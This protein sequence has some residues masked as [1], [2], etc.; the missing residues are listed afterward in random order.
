MGS[1]KCGTGVGVRRLS[2]WGDRASVSPTVRL[3]M[4]VRG[5]KSDQGWRRI[6]EL[7]A[8]LNPADGAN[9]MWG[10]HIEYQWSGCWFP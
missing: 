2:R 9:G 6:A 10:W 1:N 4:T 3:S 5:R 7:I 8:V